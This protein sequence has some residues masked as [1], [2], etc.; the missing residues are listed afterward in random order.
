MSKIFGIPVGG[1]A[2]V[3]VGLLAVV[4]VGLLAIAI[5]VVVTLFA[6]TAAG[7]RGFGDIR[8]GGRTVSLADLRPGEVYLNAKGA[9]KLGAKAGDTIRI[10]A[11][12][13]TATARVRAVVRYAGGATDSSGLLM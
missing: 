3:L 6:S 5:G 11:G 7:L 4:L 1:L 8:T 10:L 13:S 9:D 12:S 2:V